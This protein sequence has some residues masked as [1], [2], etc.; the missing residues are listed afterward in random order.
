MKFYMGPAKWPETIADIEAAGHEL[1]DSL[2]KAQAYVCTTPNPK[3]VPQLPPSVEFVQYCYTGVDHLLDAG[4]IVE[5]GV[6]WCNTAG[7]FAKPV[8]ESALG[9]LLSQAHHHKA[10]ALAA[11]WDVAR[12]LDDSQAWLY[13]LGSGVT[14]H[15]AIFGAGGIGRELI[16]LLQPFGVHITAV[17]RSGRAVAGADETVAMEHAG[18]VWGKADFV[19]NILPLTPQTQ[20]LID[21]ATFQAMKPTAV[22]VNVGRGATV[23]TDDLV[24]AVKEGQI[25]G[26]ALEVVDPEPLPDGHPLYGLPNV[27]LT[28]HMGASASVAKYHLGRVFNANAQAFQQGRPMPTH[29]DVKAG[30]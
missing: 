3:K 23:V 21:Y 5:G 15:V 16:R 4:V 14:R 11:T 25:A 8:A 7:A 26:A 18:E 9:L 22:F 28:P 12:E 2:D 1:V 6:P 10:F 27:T 20:G 13:G 29:I 19:V 24:R 30:Y 17:N